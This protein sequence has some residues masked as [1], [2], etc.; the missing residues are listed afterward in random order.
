MKNAIT[1][2]AEKWLL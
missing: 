1:S 2:R